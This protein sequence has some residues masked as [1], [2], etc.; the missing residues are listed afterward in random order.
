[1]KKFKI[2]HSIIILFF[3]FVSISNAQIIYE[4]LNNPVYSFLERMAVKKLIDL[5]LSVKPYSKKEIA[6]VLKKLRKNINALNRVEKEELFWYLKR[7]G[8]EINGK[9]SKKLGEF[10]YSTSSALFRAF[11]IAGYEISTV[12]PAKGYSKWIGARFEGSVNKLSLFFEYLDTGEFGDN[13]DVNK[14]LTPETGH[15]YKTAPNG[16]EFSDVKGGIIYDFGYGSLSLKKNYVNWGSGKFGKLFLSSKAASFP[17]VEFKLNPLPWLSIS[18]IHGWLNSMVLDSSRF[19]Y[20]YQ[21]NIQPFLVETFINKYIAANYISFKPKDWLTFSVGNSFI[22]SGDLR[23][24]MFIPVMYYKVMD[25]NTGRG[26]VNDGNGMIFFDLNVNYFKNINLYGSLL[27]DVLEIRPLL[28][29]E[30]YKSWFGITTG[31]RL[32]DLGFENLDLFLEY[33][34][35]N[36][37][38]YENKYIT[39][40][41]KH[42]GYVL[43]HWIGNNADLLSF[44]LNYKFIAN[45]DLSLKG[46][47]F[48]KGGAEDIYY[49][50]IERKKLP[51]L[52]GNNR[53]EFSI[54]FSAV[55]YPLHNLYVKGKYR[56]SSIHDDEEARTPDFLL[57]EKNSF[58]L[59]VSYGLP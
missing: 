6:V 24:E 58:I 5:N 3:I 54:E 47:I 14:K 25:H 17:H 34:M 59:S 1:M 20:S 15:F 28:K 2:K 36:P 26:D 23:P 45:L 40:N 8:L 18:Y 12:G 10:G 19:Y 16:I 38:I 29:G 53:R 9:P 21:G 39:T 42:L 55:Y 48:R 32:I 50:Y 43:G 7:Y 35:L 57:G 52:F 31:A 22:Y 51:F 33:S 11:P 41:Y 37:W 27:I 44:R 56:Y 4:T 13:V 49:A 30:F 46:E